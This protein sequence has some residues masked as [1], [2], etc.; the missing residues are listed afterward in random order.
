MLKAG[1]KKDGYTVPG[2]DDQPIVDQYGFPPI[3][4]SMFLKKDNDAS[5]E[6]LVAA[7]PIMYQPN[8]TIEEK[9][10]QVT[11]APGQDLEPSRARGQR[12]PPSMD[13]P[14]QPAST[15]P[16]NLRPM[17]PLPVSPP[18]A[19]KWS[20]PS[21][22]AVSKG[23]GRPRKYQ[24]TGMP[25]DIGSWSLQAIENLEKSRYMAE[26]YQRNKIA[27]EIERRIEA[28]EEASIVAHAVLEETDEERK[29]EGLESLST[30]V[31]NQILHQFLG[32]PLA[33]AEDDALTQLWKQMSRRQLNYVYKPSIAAHSSTFPHC[34]TV[35]ASAS[36][37][38]KKKSFGRP[39]KPTSIPYQP[40]VAAHTGMAY[41]GTVQGAQIRDLPKS[42]KAK[43]QT[44]V[45]P[46][47]SRKRTSFTDEEGSTRV[48]R[49]RGSIIDRT[50]DGD[51]HPAAKRLKTTHK[52]YEGIS[53]EIERPSNGL[54][55]GT[56]FY[57]QATNNRPRTRGA[58]PVQLAIFR[59]PALQ[60]QNWKAKLHN[61]D[62][63]VDGG[64]HQS[65]DA[66][67]DALISDMV[68]RNPSNTLQISSD[69]VVS[70]Y[71]P[72]EPKKS[73]HFE[74]VESWTAGEAIANKDLL[75]DLLNHNPLSRKHGGDQS[76]DVMVPSHVEISSA[77]S[78]I[79]QDTPH[80]S[81][82]R[83]GYE[84]PDF[85]KEIRHNQ[86]RN[87]NLGRG[88]LATQERLSEELMRPPPKSVTRKRLKTR[89][90]SR[91]PERL[92][93]TG[94]STAYVRRDIILYLLQKCG[95]VCPGPR[96]LLIP[97]IAEWNARGHSGGSDINTV[98]NAV[99]AVQSSGELQ[100]IVFTFKTRQ[101]LTAQSEVIAL[102]D[103]EVQDPR[104]KQVQNGV[105][106]RHPNNYIPISILPNDY[107]LQDPS[108][109]GL[110]LE[111]RPEDRMVDFRVLQ[112]HE[113]E[114][115]A[116][117]KQDRAD[118]AKEMSRRAPEERD[119][120]LLSLASS[121]LDQEEIST[122]K[123]IAHTKPRAPRG[124]LTGSST[125]KGKTQPRQG[126]N[127]GL[128]S[129]SL[130][131]L[132]QDLAFS[133]SN[134]DRNRPVWLA[135]SAQR[136]RISRLSYIHRSP[137]IGSSI[138]NTMLAKRST[139]ERMHELAIRAAIIERDQVRAR[140]DRS[141]N[142]G[143]GLESDFYA[144][145]RRLPE[146]E[147][148]ASWSVRRP[149]PFSIWSGGSQMFFAPDRDRMMRRKL[150]QGLMNPEQKFLAS[151]GTFSTEFYG[152]HF[153]TIR[154]SSRM[155]LQE[156]QAVILAGL[157]DPQHVF[158][159]A[160]GTF[161]STFTALPIAAIKV[162]KRVRAESR[163]SRRPGQT[164]LPF[165][166][167]SPIPPPKMK[168]YQQWG[169][170]Q[171]FEDQANNIQ[172][173]ELD[174]DYVRDERVQGW[175][176]ISYEFPHE[177][178][179][180]TGVSADLDD[181]YY[182][183]YDRNNRPVNTNITSIR[184]SE[185]MQDYAETATSS[186]RSRHSQISF[187]YSRRVYRPHK[188]AMPLS[189]PR[190]DHDP[191]VGEDY[192]T[193]PD[194][195]V[196]SSRNA[197]HGVFGSSRKRRLEFSGEIGLQRHGQKRRHEP[198][199]QASVLG[200][201]ITESPSNALFRS[202]KK[203]R[204]VRGQHSATYMPTH[205]EHRLMVAVIVIRILT[206]G[207]G[208]AIDWP[209]VATV[210]EP[211][212]SGEFIRSRWSSVLH[213][214]KNS[215]EQMESDFQILFI[216]AYERGE[217][218]IDYNNLYDFNWK[219]LVIW[220]IST[221]KPQKTEVVPMLTASR[222]SFDE[223]YHM[224]DISQ[225]KNADIFYDFD[226]TFTVHTKAS[227]VTRYPYISTLHGRPV[228]Q[229]GVHVPVSD[230]EQIAIA[231]TWIRANIS[232]PEADYDAHVAFDKIH[233]FSDSTIH[234]SLKSL[235]ADRTITDMSV[236]DASETRR[237][238]VLS[239]SLYA[240]LSRPLT[241]AHFHRAASFKAVLD[242]AF[243]SEG[244]G[245]VRWDPRA[246][247]GDAMAVMN[248]LA[249]RRV[250]IIPVDLPVDKWGLTD[251]SYVTRTMDKSRLNFNM[252]IV[253]AAERYLWGNPLKSRND[254]DDNETIAIPAAPSPHLQAIRTTTAF[255]DH[256]DALAP[257][258]IPL[259]YSIHDTLIIE[260]WELSVS[261]V[262]GILAMRSGASA[263]EIEKTVRPAM[264]VWE[265][266]EVLEWMVDAQ[267][268]VRTGREGYMVG[269]W[270]WMG[271]DLLQQ[272]HEQEI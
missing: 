228:P 118:L 208:E 204:R 239:S 195:H 64:P 48:P 97:F 84:A 270:W 34:F 53:R 199:N 180:V 260:L 40:S 94:G 193:S 154:P 264:E 26:K 123:S 163:R 161:S 80:G 81:Q 35:S 269:E 245:R 13:D 111:I 9:V 148:F 22:P 25:D 231:R 241:P 234:S 92:Y 162:P 95:G 251:G 7:T 60:D 113:R 189:N 87:E 134:L 211:E 145:L 45:K 115:R 69:I 150:I 250:K 217:F 128:R 185:L 156:G 252:D 114:K 62:R 254:H 262:M 143:S 170:K 201:G 255:M 28:G 169:K 79:I 205:D 261:S 17:S 219:G 98:K 232:T 67:G 149:G 253:P 82:V 107:H 65:N 137:V 158:H 172:D 117:E 206:G 93:R 4:S 168:I 249:H 103:I 209:L 164:S 139:R 108:F 20:R 91:T 132:P 44:S 146:F 142:D 265:V 12:R 182:V 37:T 105:I 5:L 183:G 96:A 1:S 230:E 221:L 127:G 54:F 21:K 181:L 140:K 135:S 242:R 74:A 6:D 110:R 43:K 175:P 226:G 247:D 36:K 233:S 157:M 259:W 246:D 235:V 229:D 238:Y 68:G 75:P 29:R 59:L 106:E 120:Y 166:W 184:A 100:T 70:R 196:G 216:K 39:L 136:G 90:T 73:S 109:K 240:R 121:G 130:P 225:E 167:R 47:A 271:L 202:P 119:A 159:L 66:T 147:T 210:F 33:P 30:Y 194:P 153:T 83:K 76:N 263:A 58:V 32:E 122:L 77:Q 31:I 218:H 10:D 131:W 244:E 14:L 89:A 112:Q 129:S 51:V 151:T 190:L 15:A 237:K 71:L 18:P 155:T 101:G 41:L 2:P 124:S 258:K 138:T 176:F 203:I 63:N 52:E 224:K 125:P 78:M 179:I 152:H 11:T 57:P 8:T 214:Y 266:R 85:S 56:P 177:H 46:R 191:R 19:I 200:G 27:T 215:R 102:P 198:P 236:E 178:E 212:Y 16:G 186:R 50:D 104:V 42:Q 133:D 126:H 23:R 116:N 49:K 88:V 243:A 220:T 222:I 24:A 55:I 187:P 267:I 257:R 165:G 227:T 38:A 173:W 174:N 223:R 141:S 188:L 256:S 171:S 207:L 248:L 192:Q 197:V 268:A 99:L 86:T 144:G 61:A 272:G 160:T 3:S 72:S 213:K